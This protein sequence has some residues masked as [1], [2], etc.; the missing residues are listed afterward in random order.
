VLAVVRER[1][2]RIYANRDRK[3]GN[4]RMV[5]NDCQRT[6]KFMARRHEERKQLD[7]NIRLEDIRLL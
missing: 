6:V 5:R 2:D 3:F 4:G 1:Y 7:L